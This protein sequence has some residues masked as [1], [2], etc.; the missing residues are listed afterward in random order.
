MR[1]SAAGC[2]C[3]LLVI[4]F[5]ISSAQAKVTFSHKLPDLAV[6][7]SHPGPQA[8][9]VADL[10]N[11]QRADIVAVDPGHNEVVV[12]LNDGAGGFGPGES[13]NTGV[14]PVAVAVGDF[15]HDGRLDIVTANSGGN[16]V[17]ILLAL[18]GG[19]FGAPV[20]FFADSG[21]VGVVVALLDSDQ[22]NDL[23]VLNADS[24]YLLKG[25][26]SGG[27]TPFNPA[28]VST[29]GITGFAIAAGQFDRNNNSFVDLA[30]SDEDTGD[31]FV[32]FGHG[33]G[34]FES[35]VSVFNQADFPQGIAVADFNNDNNQDIAVVTRSDL[36]GTGD[37]DVNL[38]IVYGDGS[39]NFQDPPDQAP[40]PSTDS[41]VLSATDLDLD[42]Q[43]D[44]SV[45]SPDDA[46]SVFCNHVSHP[47][48]VCVD[49]NPLASTSAGFQLQLTIGSLVAG[50]AAIQGASPCGSSPQIG[51]GDINGDGLADLVDFSP[52]GNAIRV[53]INTSSAQATPTITAT[54]SGSVSPTATGLSSPTPTGPTPTSTPTLPPVLTAT[55]TPI[56][57]PYTECRTPVGGE[58]VAV[59]VARFVSG[60]G[61]E[62]AFA[63]AQQNKVFV[64][65]SNPN[66]KGNTACAVL[67]LGNPMP[68]A[69]VRSPTGLLAYD[70][71]KD[72]SFD[73]AVVGADGVTVLFGDGRG[74]FSKRTLL[75]TA[76]PPT[77]IAAADFNRDRIPDI[78][79]ADGTST[80]SLFLGMPG[81][82]FQP[83]CPISA[84]SLATLI[85]ANDPEEMDLNGDG[86]P[87][88]AVGSDQSNFLSVFLR[89]PPSATP[90]PTPG[91]LTASDFQAL[92][93]L[94]LSAKPNALAVGQLEPPGNNLPDFGAAQTSGTVFLYLG[95]PAPTP[96]VMYDA[97]PMVSV[98]VPPLTTGAPMLS[99]IGSGDVNGD[100]RADLI[101]ADEKNDDIVI[102]LAAPD[103]SF[104]AAAPI[105]VGSKPMG[106][107]V[108]DIDGDLRADVVTANAGTNGSD[109]SISVLISSRPPPTPIPPS[110]TA[111]GTPTATFTVTPPETSTGTPT[112]TVTPTGTRTFAPTVTPTAVPTST[113]R[114]VITLNGSCA[115]DSAHT[116]PDGS[117]LIL[118]AVVGGLL[119]YRRRA[120][121]QPKSGRCACRE[122]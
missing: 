74:A 44:I 41:M 58:P 30:V 66:S 9:A 80:V 115:L 98:P 2:V 118:W 5:C 46:V 25:D 50:A 52:Q 35:S 114:G 100:R 103:G 117:V 113:A 49:N 93:A 73:L 101:V 7:P 78:I 59:A 110:P 109:G 76:A 55:P 43:V 75:Q 65:P 32:L 104:A 40:Q 33:D 16:T 62:I 22:N 94:N 121:R 60:A 61:P 36:S 71:D 12:F 56:P 88:F 57:V 83:A 68:V 84:G 105:P 82:N 96:G 63:D 79:V 91:C 34:T 107:W 8:I 42:G 102:L 89:K 122:Q 111:T 120:L 86:W 38:W 6:S 106:M 14:G 85:V 81:Q 23:A 19:G 20:D 11:D 90:S 99:A 17:S 10:N 54:V 18:S 92:S 108:G 21:P 48:M 70:F 87:D 37:I 27:F 39:G 15:N 119:A 28:S 4:T 29:D 3:S 24:V 1:S 47:S 112:Q 77:S 64:I 53:F 95:K 26:G 116:R 67:G 45:A 13:F 97:A 51:C 31:V 69:D 72:G